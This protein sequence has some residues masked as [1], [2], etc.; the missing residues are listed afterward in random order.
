MSFSDKWSRF[1]KILI[2]YL[3]NLFSFLLKGKYLNDETREIYSL[4]EQKIKIDESR[5]INIIRILLQKK[6]E[7]FNMNI[8]KKLFFDDLLIVIS[9]EL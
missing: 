9:N 3:L 4:L 8:N 5:V 6:S 2:D 7:I 1:D